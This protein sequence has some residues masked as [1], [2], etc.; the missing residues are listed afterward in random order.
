MYDVRYN[1]TGIS[2]V[3]V[4]VGIGVLAL[5]LIFINH[6]I[7]QFV[8]ARDEALVEAKALYLTEEGYEVVRALRDNDWNTIAALSLNTDYA[9]DITTTTI[10]LGSVPEIIDSDYRRRFHVRPLYRDSNSDIVASTTAG[11]TSDSEGREVWI[12]VGSPLGTTTF[13]AIL[14]NVFP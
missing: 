8:T 14:T 3:E 4:I 6:T 5:A 1:Q 12:E 13:Q 9:L 2:V 10:A 11:A 7:S